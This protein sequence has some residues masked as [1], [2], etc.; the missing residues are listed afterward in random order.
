MGYL[1]VLG[2]YG[3]YPHPPPPPPKNLCFEN[4]FSLVTEGLV[5]VKK[6]VS[7]NVGLHTYGSVCMQENACACVLQGDYFLIYRIFS[8]SVNWMNSVP[9]YHRL[10]CLVKG[11]VSKQLLW[12]VDN[13]QYL[14]H[15]T[16]YDYV[17]MSVCLFLVKWSLGHENKT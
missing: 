17:C 14:S 4:Q 8:S 12:N 7:I 3:G 15:S 2:R 1:L 16:D 11:D 5:T 6:P 10:V 13:T 9:Y